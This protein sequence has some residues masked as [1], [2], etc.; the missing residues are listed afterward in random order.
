MII[1]K[2]VTF[3]EK[4]NT[5]SQVRR[6]DANLTKVFQSLQ[7]RVRFG[8]GTDSQFGE[9]MAGQFKQFTSNAIRNTENT[10]AHGLGKIPLGI[11]II[12]QSSVGQLYGN[13]LGTNVT[14]WTDT[15]I[16]LKCDYDSVEFLIFV[17]K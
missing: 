5:D 4:G 13:P 17:L 14:A 15:Q 12:W 7:S 9:N 10:I 1:T 2:D 11:T 16:F 6:L 3:N 8:N